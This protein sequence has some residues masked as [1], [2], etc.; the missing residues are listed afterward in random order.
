[1]KSSPP[2]TFNSEGEGCSGSA[3][4]RMPGCFCFFVHATTHCSLR[5]CRLDGPP[6]TFTL[7]APHNPCP[8]QYQGGLSFYNAQEAKFSARGATVHGSEVRHTRVEAR[9]NAAGRDFTP[10]ENTA[11]G[12]ADIKVDSDRK[13]TALATDVAAC[14][15]RR[16]GRH[17]TVRVVVVG[18]DGG[19]AHGGGADDG[20]VADL[21]GGGANDGGVANLGGGGADDGGVAD[22]GGGGA[23]DSGVAD[24]GGG[25]ADDGGVADHG[26]GGADDGG[27][28]DHDGGGADDGG[29]ADYGATTPRTRDL[30]IASD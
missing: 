23:D 19:A 9:L 3:C 21:G 26:G 15:E 10:E 25:G 17:R 14:G 12:A 24:H 30:L 22:H 2:R 4:L 20:G 16:R 8:C 1:M 28:A 11:A 7:T 13:S 5:S 27:V 29:V 6:P 18:D